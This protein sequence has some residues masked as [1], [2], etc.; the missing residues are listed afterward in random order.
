MVVSGV[1]QDKAQTGPIAK[2]AGVGIYLAVQ[3]TTADTIR[4]AVDEISA[5]P[6]FGIRAS[7]LKERYREYDPVSIVDETVQEVVNRICMYDC[8]VPWSSKAWS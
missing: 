5:G 8:E 6:R 2:Y 7:E 4:G 1:G 3:Q